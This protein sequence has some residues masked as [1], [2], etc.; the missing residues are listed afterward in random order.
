MNNPQQTARVGLFFLLGLAL[1][2]VTFETLS[3]GKLFKER[4]HTLVAGFGDLQNLKVGDDVRM[5]GVKVGSVIEARLNGRRA[6]AV[7]SINPGVQV[8]GDAVATIIMSGLIGTSYVGIDPGT[9]GA[10]A[11]ADG[12]EIR[13]KVTPDLTIVMSELGDLGKKLDT[14]FASVNTVLNGTGPE[15]GLFQRLDRLLEENGAKLSATMTNLQ[16]ITAKVNRGEGTMGKLVNDPSLHDQLL[17]AVTDLKATAAQ[18]KE[19]MGGAQA[20]I[21]QVKSGQGTIGALVYDPQTS[22]NLKATMQNIRDLSD[23][24]ARGQGTLGKLLTDDELYR[25][26]QGTMKKADRALDGMNDSGP[27]TAAGIVANA[28]F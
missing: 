28:L 25:Q 19:V 14:T 20:I 24:I 16:D 12:A 7:L 21:D 3:G 5:A 6:E 22:A 13:T 27:L 9:P 4:G 1:V 11:L 8:A 18:A 10:P 15:G 17:A 26:A 23:K 2:W